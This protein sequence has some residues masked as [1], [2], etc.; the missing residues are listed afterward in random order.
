MSRLVVAAVVEGHGEEKSAIRTVVTRVWTEVLKGEYVQVLR[1]IRQHRSKLVQR[2][3]LL[4]AVDLASLKLR[5]VS[6]DDRS[7]ILVLFDADEDLPCQLAPKLAALLQEER[8][9]LD[10]AIVLANPE[11]ET[12]F[13]AA[14]DSLTEFF[15]FSSL[16]PAADPETARQ[17]KGTV[18][19]WMHG[20]YAETI[21]QVR[22]TAAM[23]LNLCR[24]RSKSFDK[25]CRE[26]G[27]RL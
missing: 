15:D 13:V 27:K 26:L 17:Q 20:R 22:L 25:L 9:H 19:R 5:E 23:D 21:D 3:G 2:E 12:W 24:S 8:P 10:V 16:P 6:P 11:F 4:K 18:S 7:L 14:A 1:P